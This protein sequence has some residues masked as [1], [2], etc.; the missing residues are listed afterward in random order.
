[1][2]SV[3]R[4]VRATHIPLFESERYTSRMFSLPM[5]F[6]IVLAAV[7]TDRRLREHRAALWQRWL[8][9]A[10]LAVMAIDISGSVRLWRVAV[11]AGLAGGQI[12]APVNVGFVLRSDPAYITTIGIGLAISLST[13][14]A[15]VALAMRERPRAA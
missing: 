1:M 7:A 15:L 4:L 8:A 3:Y 5:T 14:I 9:L 13:A 12:L 11:S 6:M 2:G 10:A